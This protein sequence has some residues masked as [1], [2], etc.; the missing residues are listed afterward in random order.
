LAF[1]F[2]APRGAFR[3]KYPAC[4]SVGRC[5][6][7]ARIFNLTHNYFTIS[8]L[9]LIYHIPGVRPRL[10]VRCPPYRHR[11]LLS[12]RISHAPNT[13]PFAAWLSPGLVYSSSLVGV[14][15]GAKPVLSRSASITMG[16]NTHLSPPTNHCYTQIN[17][18]TQTTF[19]QLLVRV[20]TFANPF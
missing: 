14:G 18:S 17:R 19:Q 16:T 20:R 11:V 3:S 8:N 12:R 4:V 7:L 1:L 10:R 15:G 9:N 2:R 13:H 6:R 5:C